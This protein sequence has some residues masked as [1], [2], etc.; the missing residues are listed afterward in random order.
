[1]ALRPRLSPGVPLSRMVGACL[2]YG[3]VQQTSI[4]VGYSPLT[5]SKWRLSA[6]STV[7]PMMLMK[8]G[9]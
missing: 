1:V 5:I 9:R 8:S 4:E 2:P 7:L 6:R 3:W